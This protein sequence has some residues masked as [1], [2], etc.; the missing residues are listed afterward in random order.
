MP[1]LCGHC[2]TSCSCGT[3]LLFTCAYTGNRSGHPHA[4]RALYPKQMAACP[5]AAPRFC[6]P[7]AQRQAADPGVMHLTESYVRLRHWPASAGTRYTCCSRT[8][9]AEQTAAWTLCDHSGR[10]HSWGCRQGSQG[11]TLPLRPSMRG[12]SSSKPRAPF[13]VSSVLAGAA[14]GTAASSGAS[15]T[16]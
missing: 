16:L 3:Y 10:E 2:S 12:T 8:L 15:E 9:L 5:A 6:C 4:C 13:C 11:L 1:T 14:A 7:P